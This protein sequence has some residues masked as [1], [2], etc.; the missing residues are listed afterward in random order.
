MVFAAG[1][2]HNDT[3]QNDYRALISTHTPHAGS[4]RSNTFHYAG[5]KAVSILA[6]RAESDYTIIWSSVAR[7]KFLSTPMWATKKCKLAAGKTA[8]QPTPPCREATVGGPNEYCYGY[9]FQ[10]THPAGDESGK[11]SAA[12]C[13]TEISTHAPH[14]GSDY[15]GSGIFATQDLFQSAL[16]HGK[17]PSPLYDATFPPAFQPTPPCGS[18]DLLDDSRLYHIDISTPSPPCGSETIFHVFT[19]CSVSI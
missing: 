5:R 9:T 15:G 18:D 17:R 10:P 12:P 7:A 8:F 19:F 2:C 13:R 6:P 16:P 4:D 11:L 3:G 14:A 1:F